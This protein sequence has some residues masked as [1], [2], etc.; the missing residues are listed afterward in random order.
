MSLLN[1]A[2]QS[3]D[4]VAT[5]YSDPNGAI[6]SERETLTLQQPV[7]QAN[8]TANNKLSAQQQQAVAEY[9]ALSEAQ[10]TSQMLSDLAQQVRDVVSRIN[11]ADP[12]LLA[13]KPTVP[14][15]G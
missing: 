11:R 5:Q 1:Q 2:A 6:A 13:P 4:Q 3:L 12:T 14:R 8:S 9:L 7:L 10:I 15:R